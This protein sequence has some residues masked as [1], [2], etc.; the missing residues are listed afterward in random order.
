M[1]QMLI[2]DRTGHTTIKWSPKRVA[3]VEAARAKFAEMLGRGY[4]AFRMEPNGE[5][6]RVKDF[7]A[8]AEKTLLMP[9]L[10]G[11]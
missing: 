9:Q 3:E 5:A 4:Q 11:G 1:N 7:D 8:T 6:R 10:V 2:M